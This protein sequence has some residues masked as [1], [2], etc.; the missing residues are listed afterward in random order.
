MRFPLLGCFIAA[1]C[2]MA[3]AAEA[4]K[5]WKVPVEVKRLSNGLTVVV[6][7]DHGSPT[8]GISIVYR[9]GFRLEPKN[10]TGFAHLFE[11]MMFEG[12]PK[13]PKG[14]FDKVIQSGGGI[15]NGSTRFD[16]TNYIESAPIS[17]LEPILWLEADRMRALAFSERNL[18][19][20][21]D[22]VK[23]EIRVNVQNQPYGLFFWTDMT[24]LAF[25]KWENAH[26]GYG[27]FKDLE[28][29]SVKD[30]EAFHQA[31][32][33]PNNAVLGIAGDIKPAEAF[34]LAE[35][36]FGPLPAR[37]LTPRPDVREGLGTGEKRLD[38]QDALA[39]VPALAIG[40]RMP[41][42]GTKDQAAMAVL[43]KALCGGSASRF[44]QSLVKG[45]EMLLSLDGGMNWPLGDP[46]NYD[47]PTLLTLFAIYKPNGTPDAILGLMD[48]EIARVVK[49]G[50]P[51]D[52]LQALKARMLAEHYSN[53]ELFLNRADA[54][55]QAQA[56]EGDAAA[57]NARPEKISA[58]TAADIKRVAT[59][60][61]TPA[62]RV[63]INRVPKAK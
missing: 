32:Y 53:L 40:W 35:K 11:H 20:Q 14:T 5:T 36:Y 6:S 22:V 30:V 9:V 28:E 4:A 19:N 37:T 54:L 18:K 43:T 41:E 1:S 56:L 60:Y 33:G 24:A 2:L 27:S 17:A 10:R 31:Y 59:T 13:A 25:Q 29:A 58:V 55:A 45:K 34:A 26:D 46:W 15:L 61:L 57:L 39:R 7:E 23:E 16:F 12:T 51:E 48:E 42:R 63:V 62:N 3:P 47:G 52:E 38:Q 49:N 50:L 44:Y 8:V 21:Q